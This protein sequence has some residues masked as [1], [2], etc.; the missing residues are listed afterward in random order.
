MPHLQDEID[1]QLQ[2]AGIKKA[3]R[4]TPRLKMAVIQ[5]DRKPVKERKRTKLRKVTNTHMEEEL[6]TDDMPV[7][8]NR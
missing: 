7:A 5:D 8:I 1:K 6:F 4:T 3:K 2:A